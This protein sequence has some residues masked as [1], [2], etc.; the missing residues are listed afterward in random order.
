MG[1][2]DE[3]PVVVAEVLFA[4]NFDLD[5]SELLPDGSPARVEVI[6]DVFDVYHHELGET[7]S[8][9]NCF[10]AILP[11]GLVVDFECLHCLNIND[12]NE[13]RNLVDQH[14]R[15]NASELLG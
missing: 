10:E 3:G 12:M 11:V 2:H 7:I 9:Q 15:P 6:V 8:A 4:R 13:L 5:L 14:H 1:V